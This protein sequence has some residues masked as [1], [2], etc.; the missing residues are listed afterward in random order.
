MVSSNLRIKGVEI[1]GELG[2]SS[3]SLEKEITNF[4]KENRKFPEV[5]ELPIECYFD[6]VRM[7]KISHVIST[8]GILRYYYENLLCSFY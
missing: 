5:I 4:L 6:I 8:D 3:Y 1:N 2:L 7:P